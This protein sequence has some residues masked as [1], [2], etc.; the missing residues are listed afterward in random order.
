MEIQCK[1]SW[2]SLKKQLSK[3]INRK[4]R[5]MQIKLIP[6]V[7][8]KPTPTINPPLLSLESATFSSKSNPDDTY[9]YGTYTSFCQNTN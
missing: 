1:S 2:K 8:I 4:S 7:D 9:D 5:N 3:L 6:K